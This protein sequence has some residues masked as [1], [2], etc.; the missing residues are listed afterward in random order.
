VNVES[1]TEN[2]HYP[3]IGSYIFSLE[4]LQANS[5]FQLWSRLLR[6]TIAEN[7]ALFGL[8]GYATAIDPA[9]PKVGFTLETRHEQFMQITEDRVSQYM[10]LYLEEYGVPIERAQARDELTALV[11]LLETVYKHNNQNNYGKSDQR[12]L[13]PKEHHV[14][15]QQ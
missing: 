8:C 11:C 10:E 4:A 1:L 12:L 14:P 3:F 9:K 15:N 7:Q 13:E 6:L 5:R 2:S